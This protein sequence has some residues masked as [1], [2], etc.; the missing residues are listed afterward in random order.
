M[1]EIHC[2]Q[3]EQII[4]EANEELSHLHSAVAAGETEKGIRGLR[5]ARNRFRTATKIENNHVENPDAD[6][7]TTH[8]DG[9]VCAGCVG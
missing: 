8:P 6:C 7:D 4:R 3:L 1:L 9:G 5:E 2:H